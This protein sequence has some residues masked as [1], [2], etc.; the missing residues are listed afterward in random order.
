MSNFVTPWT[1]ACQA[2]LSILHC[3]LEFAQTHVH[4]VSDAIPPPHPLYHSCFK[5]FCDNSNISA[6]YLCIYLSIYIFSA[7]SYFFR[8]CFC[9]SLCL[10]ISHWKFNMIHWFNK[11]EKKKQKTKNTEASRS[12]WA[13]Q[14]A[15]W[16]GVCW[17]MQET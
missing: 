9:L 10:V 14:W 17:P 5:S 13:F 2:F 1:T 8:L 16:K 6:I 12:L 3:L 15:Q 7:V 4:W 11:K